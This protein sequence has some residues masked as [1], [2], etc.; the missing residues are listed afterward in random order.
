MIR[1]SGLNASIL[2]NRSDNYGG[3]CGNSF[4]HFCFVRFGNDFMYFIASLLPMYF[5]SY[6]DGVPSIDIILCT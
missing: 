5:M 4:Y 2:V 3:I 6:E 1:L